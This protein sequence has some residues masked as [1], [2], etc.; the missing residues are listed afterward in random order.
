[1]ADLLDEY[2]KTSWHRLLA[3]M[4]EEPLTTVNIAVQTEVDVT[5]ASPKADII[6]LRREG[7][8]WT[9]EQK[10]W[11]ADGMHDTTASNLLIE[12]KFTESLTNRICRQLLV[13]DH[14]YQEK[15]RLQRNELTSFLLLSKTPETDILQRH[16][17]AP[18]DK[19]GVYTSR[20]ELFDSIRVI[21]LNELSDV[22][23]N[24][25]WKCFA[26][27]KQ[28]WKK[29]FDRIYQRCLPT[30]SVAH[31]YIIFGIRKIRME[32]TMENMEPIGLTPEYVLDLGRREWLASMM[33]AMPREELLKMPEAAGIQREGEA[34]LLVR[35]LK[36]RFGELPAIVHEKIA[37]ANSESL[38]RWGDLVLDARSL[39]DVFAADH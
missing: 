18:T 21:L 31:E 25:I 2:R 28:E 24:A 23:H 39:D 12:F 34:K 27:R 35:Q 19:S 5:S 29:A 13:Y 10:R 6:L 38:E 17:F 33:R 4:V 20:I 15:Q 11:L 1:M 22:P 36:R 3:Q 7:V 9:E 32:G 26:S 8:G 16:G 14:L 37:V 30:L